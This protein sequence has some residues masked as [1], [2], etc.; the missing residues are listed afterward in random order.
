MKE[1]I[2]Q[3][4]SEIEAIEKKYQSERNKKFVRMAL[5]YATGLWAFLY[6]IGFFNDGDIGKVIAAYIVCAI[7]AVIFIS[8]AFAEKF[9]KSYAE[10]KTIAEIKAKIY[11]LEKRRDDE[12]INN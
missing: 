6:L 8:V 1:K 5:G 4:Y 11:E 9:E 7:A 2:R 10:I 12:C 3:L